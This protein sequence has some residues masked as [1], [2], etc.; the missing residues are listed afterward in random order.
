MS[1]SNKLFFRSRTLFGNELFFCGCNSCILFDF[2]FS[3]GSGNGIL[4]GFFRCLFSKNFFFCLF[5][6]LFRYCLGLCRAF[7]G[8]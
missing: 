1:F 5:N 7:F 8:G 2:F 4:L 6:C 3:L